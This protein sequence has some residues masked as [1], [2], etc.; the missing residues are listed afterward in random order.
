MYTL[1]N[2][3]SYVRGTSTF[4][5]KVVIALRARVAKPLLLKSESRFKRVIRNLR[6]KER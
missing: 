2:F 5:I 1:N 4:R 6:V 3:R